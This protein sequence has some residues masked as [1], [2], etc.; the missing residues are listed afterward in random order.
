MKSP[1]PTLFSVALLFAFG[2]YSVTQAL[3]P[4]KSSDGSSAP[5]DNASAKEK[6][7]DQD[8]KSDSTKST[9]KSKKRV[10]A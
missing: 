10:C 5:K 4:T 9:E 1:L 7:D 8:S 6:G 3:D 2:A